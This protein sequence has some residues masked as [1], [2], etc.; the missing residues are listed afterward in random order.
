M[1]SLFGFHICNFL[2]IHFSLFSGNEQLLF[3]FLSRSLIVVGISME[4]GGLNVNRS[5]EFSCD[6][7]TRKHSWKMWNLDLI[8]IIIISFRY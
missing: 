4:Y 1:K 3:G 8:V 5:K 6:R 7:L 2:S